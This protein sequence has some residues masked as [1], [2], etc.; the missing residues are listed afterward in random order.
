LKRIE[1]NLKKIKND[2]GGI[3]RENGWGEM[4]QT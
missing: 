1:K 2:F 3:L 4:W